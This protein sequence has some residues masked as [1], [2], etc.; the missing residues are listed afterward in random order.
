MKK[1]PCVTTD[2]S[3]HAK[4]LPKPN[5]EGQVNYSL[6]SLKSQTQKGDTYETAYKL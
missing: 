1:A 2:Q 6:P 4:S 5:Q 3:T